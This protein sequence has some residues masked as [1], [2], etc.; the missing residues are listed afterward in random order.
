MVAIE[1]LNRKKLE[2]ML[3]NSDYISIVF[4]A[5][6]DRDSLLWSKN[7]RVESPINY[8]VHAKHFAMPTRRMV[9][10]LIDM[11]IRDLYIEIIDFIEK[12]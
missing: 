3:F 6:D 12:K 4:Y 2:D 10:E 1:L 8:T 9:S 11:V 5:S 7:L